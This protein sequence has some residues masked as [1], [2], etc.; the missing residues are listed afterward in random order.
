[1]KLYIK[2]LL[3]LLILGVAM[4]FILKR[5]DG[6]PLMTISDLASQDSGGIGS[7][8][9]TFKNLFK[10]S[11]LPTSD[12]I[13]SKANKL[14]NAEDD[15]TQVHKWLGEKGQWHF[16]DQKPDSAK[17]ELLR[18]NP[19]QN[20]LQLNDLKR[21]KALQNKHAAEQQTTP[22]SNTQVPTDM[23]PGMPTIGQAKKAIEQAQGIQELLNE[24]MKKNEALLDN[25]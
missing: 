25:L 14:G 3:F 24:R 6:R 2:V 1:M 23:V 22:A 21:L 9:S 11:Q 12:S 8:L 18:I 17:T 5:P 15:F 19:N 13:I 10:T 4:P 7:A 20:I 16:S